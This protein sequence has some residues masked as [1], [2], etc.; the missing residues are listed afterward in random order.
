MCPI[1]TFKV[2]Q[3]GSSYKVYLTNQPVL[4][5]DV[6]GFK[7]LVMK[8]EQPVLLQKMLQ[9]VENIKQMSLVE[10]GID[11]WKDNEPLV[12][13]IKGFYPENYG[14]DAAIMSDTIIIF[15]TTELEGEGLPE[16][17]STII[18]SIIA[19]VFFGY[20]LKTE[21]LL[22][23]GAVTYG[24]YCVIDNPRVAFGKA[25]IDA[26]E[27]EQIQDWGGILLAP[28][29]CDRLRK[30]IMLQYQY[31]EYPKNIIKDKYKE[32]FEKRCHDLA[33]PPIALN[34]PRITDD[35][36]WTPIY[37]EVKSIE[38]K[39]LREKAIEKVDKTREFYEEMRKR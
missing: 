2:P 6:L 32:K 37:A 36:D 19:S 31:T 17:F 14:V 4:V 39:K 28:E 1:E 20:M 29:L 11:F 21:K 35:V 15:P 12:N 30:S 33:F 34:W 22:I 27:L 3:T 25:I 16:E 5:C 7:N 38:D 9:I 13:K 26:Y 24:E 23:R 10:L 18:L 8:N